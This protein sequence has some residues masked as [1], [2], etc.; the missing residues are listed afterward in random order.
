M[1][2]IGVRTP[3]AWFTADL[4]NEP[5]TGI[6]ETNDPKMLL[7]ESA[8]SSRVASI[9]PPPKAFEMAT[10]PSTAITGTKAMDVPN[11]DT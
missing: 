7:N 8:N 2:P 9:P 6:E 10:F 4:E 3:L 11:S 5:V 1:P